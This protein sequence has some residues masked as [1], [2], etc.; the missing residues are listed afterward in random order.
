M[1]ERYPRI[2]LYRVIEGEQCLGVRESI[3]ICFY[4]RRSNQEVA[5]AVLRALEVYRRAAGPQA[6]SWYPDLGGEWQELDE[7]AWELHRREMLHPGGANITLRE[8]PDSVTGYGF[9]YIGWNLED[10]PF[11]EDPGAVCAVAFWLPTE[12]LEA[13]GPAR[14]RELALE[15]AAE[16]PF[17]SGHAGLAL[18]STEGL[19]RAEHAPVRDLCF[20]YPGLD[21]PAVPELAKSLGRSINGAHWLTFLGPPVLDALGGAA[22]L[23]ARLR[24]AGTTVQELAPERAVV[25]LG[26]WPEAGDLEKGRFLPAY[27][28]LAHVL[29]PWL[30]R[31]KGPLWHGFSKEDM[32]R[33]ERRF[34]DEPHSL[35]QDGGGGQ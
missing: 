11:G 29:E 14:V 34:L 4:M 9:R 1:T 12:Y 30:Y 3:S 6:L 32:D 24:F 2:R 35:Q 7:K 8:K 16:L 26:E 33:W 21:R 10:L 20:R 22:G 18:H 31:A 15:L 23:R 27:R 13:H 19:V 25:T 28:E 5:P 17:N